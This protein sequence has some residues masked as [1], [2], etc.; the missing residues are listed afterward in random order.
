MNLK[1]EKLLTA[2]IAAAIG[3]SFIAP[4]PA[5]ARNGWVKVSCDENLECTYQKNLKRSGS[6]VTVLTQTPDLRRQEEKNCSDWSYR[7][8]LNDG[9]KSSWEDIMP[10]SIG[11]TMQELA[12][13]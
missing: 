3:A 6:I 9:S 2:G 1:L 7:Y 12:C 11:E 5:E 13:R 10:G 8:A 4:N